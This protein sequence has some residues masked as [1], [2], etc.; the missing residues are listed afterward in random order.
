MNYNDRKEYII[1]YINLHSTSL[2]SVMNED[3][4]AQY[5]NK[6]SQVNYLDDR[7]DAHELAYHYRDNLS[8]LKYRLEMMGGHEGPIERIN[9]YHNQTYYNHS[10]KYVFEHHV[11]HHDNAPLGIVCLQREYIKEDNIRV[12]EK[13][14]VEYT[15]TI[16]S[17]PDFDIQKDNALNYGSPSPVYEDL[18]AAV[19]I[20]Y[21]DKVHIYK[22]IEEHQKAIDMIE[23]GKA[24]LCSDSNVPFNKDRPILENCIDPV[25]VQDQHD[26]I[27]NDPLADLS[28]IE[29]MQNEHED[30]GIDEDEYSDIDE[31]DDENEDSSMDDAAD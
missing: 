6:P 10:Y 19:F 3:L 14:Y 28:D 22:I 23:E 8:D 4:R 5:L 1:S 12:A 11:L 15:A 16:N 29:P 21:P 26:Y 7:T 31:D 27:N 20:P 13:L 9:A 18:Q 17:H 24:P 25:H 30:S 2:K